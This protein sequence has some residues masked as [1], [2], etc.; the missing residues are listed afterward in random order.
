MFNIS[1]AGDT[2][3]ANAGAVMHFANRQLDLSNQELLKY[4]FKYTT[5]ILKII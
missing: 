5:E 4:D 3:H 1:V 2:E